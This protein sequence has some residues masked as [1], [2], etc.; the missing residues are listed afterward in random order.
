[1]PLSGP[2]SHQIRKAEALKRY[3]EEGSLIGMR[4]YAF[5][6]FR[7]IQFPRSLARIGIGQAAIIRPSQ[8]GG[9]SG[10]YTIGLTSGLARHLITLRQKFRA[11][12]TVGEG[13]NGEVT[14]PFLN[15][16]DMSHVIAACS[17][18]EACPLWRI[19]VLVECGWRLS[20]L[21]TTFCSTASLYA[22]RNLG[23]LGF[24]E[25]QPD[26]PRVVVSDLRAAGQSE[27]N[28]V[29]AL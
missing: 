20:L 1:M 7:A 4:P 5:G 22:A 13:P 8:N 28:L 11:S 14:K 15:P 16:P 21:C 3:F 24:P 26:L 12:P 27:R 19:L 10:K 17:F 2:Y 25:K 9:E 6:A 23:L 29:D 18:R